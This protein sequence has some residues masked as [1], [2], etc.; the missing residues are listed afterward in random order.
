[1]ELIVISEQRHRLC[2]E[3]GHVL[4]DSLD[5]KRPVFLLEPLDLLR[6]V[7]PMSL[8]DLLVP[9]L[10]RLHEAQGRGIEIERKRVIAAR[11]AIGEICVCAVIVDPVGQVGNCFAHSANR[12]R[13]V[14]V[15]QDQ[16]RP[17]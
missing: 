17:V 13:N 5:V 10:L 15:R 1:M 14:V 8:L 6:A 11:S 3:V 4:Q 16:Y 7:L 2:A 9:L 12:R